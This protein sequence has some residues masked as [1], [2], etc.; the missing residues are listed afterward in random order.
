MT[1][2]AACLRVRRGGANGLNTAATPSVARRS[3][4]RPSSGSLITCVRQTLAGMWLEAG[5]PAASGGALVPSK[6]RVGT[7]GV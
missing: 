1:L 6:S 5:G 7:R 3:Q 4:S 2:R